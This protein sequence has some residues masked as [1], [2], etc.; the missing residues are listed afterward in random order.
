MVTIS[1]YLLFFSV[2]FQEKWSHWLT[3]CQLV[4]GLNWSPVHTTLRSCWSTSHLAWFLVA[5]P[6]PGGWSS[7]MSSLTRHWLHNFVM[8]FIL[9]GSSHTQSIGK[10]LFHLC[11]EEDLC[12][13]REV[14]SISVVH[15]KK[16]DP[17]S[18][19]GHLFCALTDMG[20]FTMW[21]LTRD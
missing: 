18:R 15:T 2:L 17:W 9:A 20:I 7:F 12:V 10:H 8:N 19:E 3:E 16:S 6:W 11:Y 5:C 13:L 1:L 4:V 14:R 21:I